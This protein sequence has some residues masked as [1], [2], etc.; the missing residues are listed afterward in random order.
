M[1]ILSDC[2]CWVTG[3]GIVDGCGD[4][5]LGEWFVEVVICFVCYPVRG[6]S[7]FLMIGVLLKMRM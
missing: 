4:R 3:S 7:S 1:G 6:D 5:G 2:V